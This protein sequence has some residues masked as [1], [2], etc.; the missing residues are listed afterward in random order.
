MK[1]SV[2]DSKKKITKVLLLVTLEMLALFQ[3]QSED[4]VES[5]VSRVIAP[6]TRGITVEYSAIKES[7]S[8][9]GAVVT[10]TSKD[11]VIQISA[12]GKIFHTG[13]LINLKVKASE[14]RFLWLFHKDAS[15]EIRLIYPNK[16]QQNNWIPAN[17]EISIPPKDASFRFR[18]NEPYGN[19]VILAIATKENLT[20]PSL[21]APESTLFRV[22]TDSQ[23]VGNAITRGIRVKVTNPEKQTQTTDGKLSGAALGFKTEQS[24]SNQAK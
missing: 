7:E 6:L 4:M 24:V 22:F 23:D 15:G 16:A 14:G 17:E 18:V 12:N 10:A 19:E 9:S 1:T 20:D 21:I 8:E 2:Y 3:V 13:E 5:E 11:S